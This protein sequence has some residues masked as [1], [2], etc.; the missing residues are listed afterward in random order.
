[1]K[2]GLVVAMVK[3]PLVTFVV[4]ASKR[5]FV[6]TKSVLV[7]LLDRKLVIVPLETCRLDEKKLVI[8]PLV[9]W[10]LVKKP[11]VIVEDGETSCVDE[12]IPKFWKSS[13]ELV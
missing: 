11:V 8:V 12:E 3:I 7:E 9:F 1:M 4:V 6:A 5:V 10:I 2:I 13:V